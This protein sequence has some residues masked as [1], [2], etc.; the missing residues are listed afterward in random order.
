LRIKSFLYCPALLPE[1]SYFFRL[2]HRRFG[3]TQHVAFNN[4]GKFLLKISQDHRDN[5]GILQEKGDRRIA[6]CGDPLGHG[7]VGM[8]NQLTEIHHPIGHLCRLDPQGSNTHPG[9]LG[10]FNANT[11]LLRKAFFSGRIGK[12]P[13]IGQHLRIHHIND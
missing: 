13:H 6:R 11:L 1:K 2:E 10:L 12:Q 8:V 3:I 5:I 7:P 4:L 9:H